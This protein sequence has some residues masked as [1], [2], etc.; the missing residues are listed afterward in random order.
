MSKSF[1]IDV[2][3]PFF[4]E[5]LSQANKYDDTLI[6]CHKKE[7]LTQKRKIYREKIET[8]QRIIYPSL[9]QK[10]VAEIREKYDIPVE[11]GFD[12]YSKIDF[13]KAFRII[14]NIRRIVACPKIFLSSAKKPKIIS[15]TR[16][17]SLQDINSIFVI[18]SNSII[19]SYI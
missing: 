1:F 14:T 4:E 8:A 16:T 9:H 6:E 13:K 5:L 18:I 10:W 7:D 3:K 19:V 15:G 2:N 11:K 12:S 17:I